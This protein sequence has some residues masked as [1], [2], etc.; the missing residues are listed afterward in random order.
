[1]GV[2]LLCQVE[3]A[4]LDY[5]ASRLVRTLDPV[6]GKRGGFDEGS[7]V[8]SARYV[9]L[10]SV[11]PRVLAGWDSGRWTEA[12]RVSTRA[13]GLCGASYGS[14]AGAPSFVCARRV[15]STV[16][17]SARGWTEALRSFMKAPPEIQPKGRQAEAAYG[18]IVWGCG[19]DGACCDR[20]AAQILQTYRCHSL[21]RVYTPL[22][23]ARA[24]REWSLC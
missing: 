5:R 24:P 8:V 19:P 6:T 18:C 11:R 16:K 7:E 15:A 12:V 21:C 3:M 10:H 4:A 23:R 20:G 13:G 17:C 2:R 1:M 14:I 22:D 9:S